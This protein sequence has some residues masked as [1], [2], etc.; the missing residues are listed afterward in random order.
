MNNIQNVV[1]V[2]CTVLFEDLKKD[3]SD[4]YDMEHI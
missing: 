1:K 3:V 2:A 4:M